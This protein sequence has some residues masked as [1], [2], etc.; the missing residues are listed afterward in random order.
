[1]TEIPPFLTTGKFALLACGGAL[2]QH[3]LNHLPTSVIR[4]FIVGFKEFHPEIECD[5][6]ISVGQV[7][8]LF[9]LLRT[10]NIK[11]F[12]LAGYA[13]R[14]MLRHLRFDC[15]GL[16]T[17]WHLSKKFKTGDDNLLSSLIHIF[18]HNGFAPLSI[19]EICPAL[20]MPLGALGY[21][22]PDTQ[23]RESFNY[24]QRLLETLSPYDMGQAIAIAG[25]VVLAVETLEGTDEMIKRC[26]NIPAH[27]RK[28]LPPAIFIKSPK[29]GQTPYA[30]LPVFGL[31]TLHHLHES[32]FKGAFLKAHHLILV[33][34]D[35]IIDYAN[36][37]NLFIY[38]F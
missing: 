27:R 37:H 33:D 8:K 19:P 34:I 23:Q 4:P 18:K 9:S 29:Q 13:H 14:P 20:T 36:K 38:G 2:P 22:E 16:Y 6:M 12:C 21:Y 28:A 10:Q 11:H 17:A 3:I 25:Q 32:G 35:Q 24:G 26:Q 30:D 1:M 7:G 31:K 15:K 5:I